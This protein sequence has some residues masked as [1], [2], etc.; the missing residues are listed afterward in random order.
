MLTNN[1]AD[2]PTSSASLLAMI[3]QTATTLPVSADTLGFPDAPFGLDPAAEDLELD[4][5]F[6]E[7]SFDPAWFNL[8]PDIYYDDKNNSCG[9][10]P[11]AQI[12]DEVDRNDFQQST[13]VVDMAS[14]TPLSLSNFNTLVGTDSLTGT[15]EYALQHQFMCNAVLTVRSSSLWQLE[16][17]M[18]TSAL[19]TDEREHEMAYLIRHFTESLGPW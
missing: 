5:V 1:V 4:D 7:S 2:L 15:A 3:D 18:K 14:G 10:I 11:N 12:I 13:E 6:D 19:I 9:F 16:G 8:D 17:Q